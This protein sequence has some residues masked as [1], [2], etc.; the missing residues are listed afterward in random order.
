MTTAVC[1]V[2]LLATSLSNDVDVLARQIGERNFI[3]YQRLQKAAAYI[4]E[5]MATNGY[6]VER[7]AFT[8]RKKT[9]DNLIAELPGGALSNE[10]VVIG[11]HYDTAV[12]TPGAD[13]NAS[14]VAGLLA[15]ARMCATNRPARTVRFVAF[16]NEEPPFFWSDDMGSRR[17]AM[18]CKERRENIVAMISLESIGCYSDAEKSQ[19]YPPP[20]GFFYPSR[21]N[22]IAFVSNLSSR[23]LLKRASAAFKENSTFPLES[24]GV[25]GWTPGVWWSDHWSFWKEG[26]RAFMVTDTAPFRNPEYHDVFDTPEKLDYTRM[27]L[28]IEGMRHVV[29]DLADAK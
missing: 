5:Q 24:A 1:T 16:T 11:A 18:R 19:R 22:F 23:G 8:A 2:A 13:D 14:G 29:N 6:T 7:Q 25:P 26:Y 3:W 27:A 12:G 15:L 17:Y 4:E 21:G 28:V 10:I 9:V 20:F